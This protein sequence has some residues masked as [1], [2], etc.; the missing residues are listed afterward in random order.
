MARPSATTPRPCSSRPPSR[1]RA[2]PAPSTRP[3]A[4]S[5]SGPPRRGRY[6]QDKLY[7]KPRNGHL[8]P[9]ASERLEASPQSLRSAA[10]TCTTEPI[11]AV[12]RMLVRGKCATGRAWVYVRDDAPLGAAEIMPAALFRHSRDRS[13]DHPVDHLKK[14][15]GI[16]QADIY[17][18]FDALYEADRSPGPIVGGACCPHS[19]RKF[20]ELA[21]IADG[22]LRRPARTA[23][24][25]SGAGGRCSGWS[26]CS[27]S[28]A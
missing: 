5:A 8:A 15:S 26:C 27:I 9:A 17:A 6:D 16:F 10:S 20:Y 12:P 4:G 14:F 2:T 13:G 7:D 3:R 21:D 1:P 23:E 19:S 25:A 24:H 22:K 28:S 11:R 18:G